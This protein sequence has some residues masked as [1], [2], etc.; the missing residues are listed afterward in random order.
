MV[1]VSF[2]WCRC[3]GMPASSPEIRQTARAVGKESARRGNCEGAVRP[4]ASRCRASV[5]SL[6]CFHVSRSATATV[7][8]AVDCEAQLVALSGLSASQ[9][10]RGAVLVALRVWAPEHS[11]RSRGVHD[12]PLASTVEQAAGDGVSE[13]VNVAGHRDDDD[14]I[15]PEM[16]NSREDD[17]VEGVATHEHDH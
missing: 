7:S 1:I 5:T 13:V 6:Q 11:P 14:E 16:T 3:F 10:A 2:R 17:G 12:H 8:L 15:G 4:A 9:T